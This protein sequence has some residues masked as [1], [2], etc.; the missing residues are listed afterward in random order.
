MDLRE[1]ADRMVPSSSMWRCTLLRTSLGVGGRR[2][3]VGR[4]GGRGVEGGPGGGRGVVGG[5]AGKVDL[6][7]VGGDLRVG[8][9]WLLSSGIPPG[10]NVWS[11][12]AHNDLHC[13]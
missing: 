4:F 11:P 13:V 10:G 2:L 5:R 7:W 9:R 1:W 8:R 3:V 12:N 6:G